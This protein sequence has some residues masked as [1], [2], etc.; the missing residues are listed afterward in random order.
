MSLAF[1]ANER[2]LVGERVGGHEVRHGLRGDGSRKTSW[3]TV[4]SAADGRERDMVCS[5]PFGK[6]ER[7]TMSICQESFLIA[8]TAVPN[9]PYT[10]DDVFGWEFVGCRYRRI[11][12]SAAAQFEAFS[13]QLRTCGTMDCAIDSTATAKGAICGVHNDI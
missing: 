13:Q 4:G 7:A 9:R 2:D 11:S 12:R 3:K 8:V 10:M 6:F 1:E 5:D